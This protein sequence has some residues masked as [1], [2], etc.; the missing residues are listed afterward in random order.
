MPGGARDRAAARGAR[1]QG[2][3]V[4]APRESTDALDLSPFGAA[5]AFV[6]AVGT[7]RATKLAGMFLR[8]GER[9]A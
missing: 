1:C 5:L 2:A 7:A 3:R 8:T 6:C 9:A 4:T